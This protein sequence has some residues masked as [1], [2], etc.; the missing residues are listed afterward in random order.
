M[1]WSSSV[2]FALC[3]SA[4]S[5]SAQ[6]SG[7]R[8][9]HSS[10]G[11]GSSSH[12]SSSSSSHSSSSSSSS[13]SSAPTRVAP[14]R[15]IT[16]TIRPGEF[17]APPAAAVPVSAD[18]R[19]AVAVLPTLYDPPSIPGGVVVFGLSFGS[20]GGLVWLVT[21]K[22]SPL[23]L[24]S[25]GPRSGPFPGCDLRRITI[26]F[27]GAARPALQAA[28][29]S[30]S[31]RLDPANPQAR[32]QSIREAVALLGAHLTSARYACVQSAAMTVSAAAGAFE[33]LA[34]D[35]RGRY[36]VEAVSNQQALQM[37]PGAAPRSEEG[38]GMLVVSI[39]V[40]STEDLSELSGAI[41]REAL[42]DALRRLAPSRGDAMAGYE[43]IWSP[44]EDADRMSSAELE[45]RYPELAKIDAGAA[46]GRAQCA[47][48]QTV[49]ARELGRCP[50]CGNPPG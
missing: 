38:A 40:A 37:A 15:R 44:S 32:H 14:W 41:S 43:L 48:C 39:L 21:R 46:F 45:V 34:T 33:R 27:D 42:A 7:G 22:R 16:P 10:F 24:G 12:S 18:E 9:G 19:A 1:R 36:I 50:N 13:H 31:A 49:F 4:S 35:L 26:G 11:G 5:A 47:F 25:V 23:P 29:R 17:A 3:L 2:A 6:H 30:I 8:S 28:L 20:L